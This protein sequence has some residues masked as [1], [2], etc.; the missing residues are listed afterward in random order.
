MKSAFNILIVLILLSSVFNGRA[1]TIDAIIPI[2]SLNGPFC[3]EKY[4]P[5]TNYK[6]GITIR[7]SMLLSSSDSSSIESKN[8]ILAGAEFF[9]LVLYRKINNSIDELIASRKDSLFLS[10]HKR[11]IEE[12]GDTNYRY[13]IRSGFN[14]D[15]FDPKTEH[16]DGYY[17]YD[18]KK[19]KKC[20][21]F[22]SLES[23][24]KAI[25]HSIE[26]VDRRV[27]TSQSQLDRHIIRKAYRPTRAKGFIGGVFL[28]G[29]GTLALTFLS[30]LINM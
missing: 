14:I 15:A 20:L 1:Q 17:I 22:P 7:Q 21:S 24:V 28:Y 5:I 2:E 26:Y 25:D 3:I 11:D 6:I 10:S 27:S 19:M 29:L 4:E 30:F 8:E 16:V 23:L 12:K 13:I 9:N 18:T